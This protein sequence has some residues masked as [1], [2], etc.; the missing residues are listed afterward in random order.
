MV[1]AMD[2]G[3]A[4]PGKFDIHHIVEQGVMTRNESVWVRGVS[5]YVSVFGTHQ[6]REFV[7]G[8]GGNGYN[9]DSIVS[10]LLTTDPGYEAE[11]VLYEAAGKT[12]RRH[13]ESSTLKVCFWPM[14]DFQARTLSF[15][16][17]SSVIR[18]RVGFYGRR[19]RTLG[20]GYCKLRA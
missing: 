3:L 14:L 8:T 10:S 5:P 17:V 1:Q 11:A 6:R 20:E 12:W 16:H 7:A 2:R 19:V 9:A 18:L 4:E 15:P 13:L